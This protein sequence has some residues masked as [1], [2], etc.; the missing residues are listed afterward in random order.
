MSSSNFQRWE[1]KQ[2]SRFRALPPTPALSQRAFPAHKPELPKQLR[3]LTA[4]AT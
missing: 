2:V 4:P 3:G 1:L